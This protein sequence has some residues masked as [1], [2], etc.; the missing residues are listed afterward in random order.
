MSD[1]LRPEERSSEPVT[2]DGIAADLCTLGLE[3][4][5][6]VLVHASLSSLGW[7][8]GG[9]P[10][11]VDALQRVLTDEG[12]LVMP[13]HTIY[14]SDPS[15]WGEYS[16]PEGWHEPIRETMPPYRPAVTPTWGMGAVAECFRSCPD[17]ERIAHPMFSFA[18][19]GAGA[20]D[21]TSDHPLAPRLGEGSPLADV[22]DRDGSVLFLGT[23]HGTNTSLHLAEYRADLGREPRTYGCSVLVD[24]EREWVTFEDT[25]LDSEDFPDCGAGFEERRPAA[26]ETGTVGVAGAKLLDQRALV[27]FGVDW[28]ERTRE[29]P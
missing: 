16:V 13:T 5:D 26:V 20:S 12:T 3:T 15:R 27:D 18:A 29:T 4:G 9:P 11:V 2:V 1:T 8:C 28:M 21:V 25:P 6:T 19:W 24:G 14:N 7:V 10:A 17:V 23:T 22:Y